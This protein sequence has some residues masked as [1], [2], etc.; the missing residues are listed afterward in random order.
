VGAELFHDDRQ[1]DMTKLTAD[2]RNFPNAPKEAN[3]LQTEGW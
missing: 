1:T 3:G 2:F